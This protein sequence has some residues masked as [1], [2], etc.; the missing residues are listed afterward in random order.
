VTTSIAGAGPIAVAATLPVQT[1][2]VWQWLLVIIPVLAGAAV[3]S[4]L[5]LRSR[6]LAAGHG[7]GAALS[8]EIER[9]AGRPAWAVAGWSVALWSLTVAYVGFVWDVTWHAD[10]GRDNELFTVPHTLIVVGL[11]GLLAA[12]AAAVWL[13][14]ASKAAVGWRVGRLRVPYSAV[15]LLLLGGAAVAGFPLDDFWHATY[16]IDVTMWSPTHLLM[17]GGASLAPLALWL[18]LAE[19]GSGGG[20]DVRRTAIF[21]GG[22][23]LLGLSTFQLEY[24]LGIPQWQILFQPILIAGAA[25]FALTAARA[26]AGRGGAVL[27]VL[28][29]VA[30]RVP[31]AV[32]LGAGLG[33]SLPKFPLYLGEALA[34]DVGFLLAR[35]LGGVATAL[36]CGVL[37]STMGLATEWGWMQLW[38]Q[39][40]WQRG[41]LPYMWAAVAIAV[42]AALLGYAVGRVAAGR[43]PDVAAP[44]VTLA[45]VAVGFLVA[46]HVPLRAVDNAQADLRTEAVGSPYLVTDVTGGAAPGHDVSIALSLHPADL[47]GGAD[48][49]DV[50]AWQGHAPVRHIGLREISPGNYVSDGV[51]PV[52]GTWKSLV[53]LGHGDVLDAIPIAMPAD[54][55][56]GLPAIDPQPSR[57]LDVVPAEQLLMRE[58]HSAAQWPFV[59]I[60]SLFALS[61]IAWCASLALGWALVA[62]DR[63]SPRQAALVGSAAEWESARPRRGSSIPARREPVGRS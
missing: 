10:T 11:L 40:P 5:V 45:L 50:V 3:F 7:I 43:K 58:V 18:M 49:F 15:P 61:V 38:Y 54:P 60:V 26:A 57:T 6:A 16:G 37:V 23:V 39:Y 17:I 32:F 55:E 51:V 1:H 8:L 31:I 28:V 35:R 46:L 41:L 56:S 4:R 30:L 29:F 2:D 48:R 25:A 36:L 9:R 33:Q 24:D 20:R 13:A 59:V 19:A 34:V 62:R 27:A 21:M 12:G 44:I 53:L 14:T 63:R 22:L 52:G 42:A 47:A